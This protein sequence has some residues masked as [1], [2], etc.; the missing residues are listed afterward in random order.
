MNTDPVVRG[1]GR[2]GAIS[3]PAQLKRST[4]L[5]GHPPGERGGHFGAPA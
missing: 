4:E 1:W 3:G 2:A 5:N